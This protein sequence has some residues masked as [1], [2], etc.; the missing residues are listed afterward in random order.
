M[1][2]ATSTTSTVLQSRQLVKRQKIIRMLFYISV[3]FIICWTPF[4]VTLLI[5]AQLKQTNK[6]VLN[7]WF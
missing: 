1:R 7:V 6:V 2:Q 4:N 5:A 3:S